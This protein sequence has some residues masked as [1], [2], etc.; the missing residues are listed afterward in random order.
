MEIEESNLEFDLQQSAKLAS[1]GHRQFWKTSTRGAGIEA[2]S[3]GM[4]A[5]KVLNPAQLICRWAFICF[6]SM[7]TSVLRST[8][9]LSRSRIK[10]PLHFLADEPTAIDNFYNRIDQLKCDWNCWLLIVPL[11]Y[12]QFE[13]CYPTLVNFSEVACKHFYSQ[14][15]NEE[16]WQWPE[17]S[18]SVAS[19]FHGAI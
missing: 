4:V 8:C 15:H 5:G 19:R 14:L 13:L 10:M 12:I 7:L 3:E 9:W 18:A 6:A 1:K 16:L 17:P 2:P 11:G